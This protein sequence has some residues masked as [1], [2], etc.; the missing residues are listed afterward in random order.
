[1]IVEPLTA[2]HLR[3]IDPPLPA[4]MLVA[5]PVF[6][7]AWAGLVDG[8]VIG[9]AGV[10]EQEDEA[11]AWIVFSRGYRTHLVSISSAIR[12]WL[13]KSAPSRLAAHVQGSLDSRWMRLLGFRP[14]G[15]VTDYLGSGLDLRRYVYDERS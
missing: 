6:A 2:E 14:D 1:M 12:R 9:C 15:V 10:I 4:A 8:R 3:R 11:L 13:R 5:G 7:N